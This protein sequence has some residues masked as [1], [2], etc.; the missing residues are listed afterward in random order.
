MRTFLTTFLLFII[1]FSLGVFQTYA[2]EDI[3]EKLREIAIIDQ[4]VM[5]PMRD[6][7]VGYGYIQT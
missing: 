6:N 3:I 7:T 1:N 5:M 2:Q 4:K